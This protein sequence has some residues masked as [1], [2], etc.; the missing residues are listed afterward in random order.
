MKSLIE[1]KIWQP[2]GM[3]DIDEILPVPSLCGK[4]ISS[5]LKSPV[6][7]FAPVATSE[8]TKVKLIFAVQ[9]L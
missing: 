5:I 2:D 9:K 4:V 3:P 1:R 7:F 6:A 8:L